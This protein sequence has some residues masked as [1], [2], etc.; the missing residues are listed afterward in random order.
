[1]AGSRTWSSCGMGEPLANYRRVMEAAR[2]ING[3]LGIG[4]RKITISTVG[5]VPSIRKLAKE[6][7]QFNL[8]VS[9]HA[10]SDAERDALMPANRRFG[11]LRELMESVRFYVGETG[12][13][14]TFEWALIA[15]RNDDRPTARQFGELLAEYDLDRGR[16]HVNVIPLNET[17]GFRGSP[18]SRSAVGAFCDELGSVGGVSVTPRVRRGIDIDAGCGQLTAE[19]LRR[20]GSGR[21]GGNGRKRE[22]TGEKGLREDRKASRA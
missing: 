19:V 1:M 2:R 11:G 18:A 21:G 3:E 22:E 7:E 9:L 5:V 15:G 13:R 12:R 14:V 10:A 20:G 17:G 8:A 16:S 4:A 6:R